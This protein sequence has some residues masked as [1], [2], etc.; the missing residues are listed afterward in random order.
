M[1]SHVRTGIDLGRLAQVIELQRPQA[2][3][4]MPERSATS[5]NCWVREVGR[6]KLMSSLAGS[7][8]VQ[9]APAEHLQ[10]GGCDRPSLYKTSNTSRCTTLPSR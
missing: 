10:E 4:L 7:I 8:P 9:A 6:P 2:C 1:P 3:W 5:S